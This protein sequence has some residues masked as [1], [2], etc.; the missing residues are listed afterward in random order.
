MADRIRVTSLMG[1]TDK[2]EGLGGTFS[3]DSLCGLRNLFRPRTS[4]LLGGHVFPATRVTSDDYTSR[5]ATNPRLLPHPARPLAVGRTALQRCRAAPHPPVRRAHRADP[6]VH[7][8]PGR[9]PRPQA[10]RT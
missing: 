3:P 7:R 4:N 6:S 8:R 2:L 1:S 5:L 9:P 10:L